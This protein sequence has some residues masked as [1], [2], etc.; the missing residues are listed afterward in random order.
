M[1]CGVWLPLLN[2]I[3]RIALLHEKASLSSS[4]LLLLGVTCAA[5]SLSIPLP[6]GVCWFSILGRY[7][8]FC[9]EYSWTR[10]DI[11]YIPRT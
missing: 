7:E 1:P 8:Q 11:E 10:A 3:G 6:T 9:S 2:V 4:G 5:T